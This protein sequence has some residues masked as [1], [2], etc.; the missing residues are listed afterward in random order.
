MSTARTIGLIL[1]ATLLIMVLALV[2]PWAWQTLNGGTAESSSPAGHTRPWE[3]QVHSP[4]HV[5][6]LG[7]H[8]ARAGSEPLGTPLEDAAHR[9]PQEVM[10]IAIIQ[11]AD[12][13]LSLEAFLASVNAGPLQGKLV[14][15]AGVPADRLTRWA[16]QAAKATPQVS[17]ARRFIL[18]AED[19][20]Q[21]RRQRLDGLVFLPAARLDEETLVQRLG[22]PAERIAETPADP[23]DKDA[24][25]TVHLL[26]PDRGLA[27]AVDAKGRNRVVMQYVTPSDFE[28]RL[29]APLREQV[30]STGGGASAPVAQ[31]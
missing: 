17:G 31:P 15:T 8:L 11:S 26:Y 6:V 22:R 14:L 16:E 12:G 30:H 1:L 19:A 9:W 3:I 20:A 10:E 25:A 28:A 13:R 4:D 21:A 29:R 2:A 27:V 5:E 18:Q 7:L 23:S 24:P